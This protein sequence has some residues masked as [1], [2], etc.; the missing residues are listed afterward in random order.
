MCANRYFTLQLAKTTGAY[1]AIHVYT[2]T[3]E[4]CVMIFVLT[5]K[6]NTA[7]EQTF[8]VNNYFMSKDRKDKLF[9]CRWGTKLCVHQEY[10]TNVTVSY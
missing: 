9:E 10:K 1:N 8:W 7:E 5:L 2:H 3:R 4:K 6:A